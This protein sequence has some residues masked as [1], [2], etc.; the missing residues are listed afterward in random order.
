LPLAGGLLLAAIVL[1]VVL[2]ATSGGGGTSPGGAGRSGSGSAQAME[3]MFQDDQLLLYAPTPVVTSTLN[4]LKALGVNRLRVTV[5]WRTIAPAAGSSARPAGFVASDPGAYPP[6]GFV[7]Y[8]RLAMLA[9]E[10]GIGVNF[11]VTA[12]GPLWAMRGPPD[13]PVR[14]DVYAPYA[15]DFRQFVTAVGRRY[16]GSY[17]PPATERGAL[18]ALGVTLRGA[19]PRVDYWSIWNEPNQPGWLSPQWRV[20]SGSLTMYSPV[21]YRSYVDAAWRGLVGTGHGPGTDTI[22]IGE[23]APE[24]GPGEPVPRVEQPIPPLPFLEALYC[25][26]SSDQPLTGSAAAALAC[27]S[28]GQSFAQAHPALFDATGFAHHPYA[29][30][31]APNVAYTAPQDAGFVPLVSLPHLET[32]LDRI[33]GAYGQKRQIPIYLTEYG[34]ETNPPNPFR[35][36]TLKQQAAYLDEAQYMASQDPRVRSMSQF[37]LRDSP[38]NT[39]APVGSVAYWATFQTG[40]EFDN[41]VRKPAFAAYRLPIWI[42]GGSGAGG[43][44]I[45]VWGMIRPAAGSAHAVLQWRGASGGF[46]SLSTVAVGVLKTFTAS[47]SVP[48]PGVVRIAWTSPSGRVLYSRAATVG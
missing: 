13:R 45:T 47:V 17:V 19:L 36:V 25:V 6:T 26:N 27:P 22:L 37:L 28:G 8:D 7:L 33:F 40:I 48:G 14:A 20:V 35:D 30:F 43:G 16:S 29:F 32:A 2:I 38:P 41:G 4:T 46:R 5:L 42:P 11:D 23:L 21:L 10:R 9:R 31:L 12:A 3:S 24:G 34:Y 44:R 18:G 15:R 39:A 1:V